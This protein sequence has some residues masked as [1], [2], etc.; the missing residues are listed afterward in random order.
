MSLVDLESFYGRKPV[1]ELLKKRV[2]DLKDGY[3]QNL[4]FLGNRFVGKS[5]ILYKFVTDLDDGDV[6]PVFVDVENNDLSSFCQRYI[7]SLL[8]Y[9]ARSKGL[10]SHEDIS[11]LMET[12]QSSLPQ[13]VKAMK[14]IQSLL[15]ADKGPEAYREVLVL[16]QLFALESNKFCLLILDEFD[17]LESFAIPDVFQEL[18]KRI[19]TQ[20]R[21]LYVVTSSF[22]TAASKIL[23]EK[24][25]LLF[26]NFEVV[27][28]APFD[29]KTS[30]G[31]VQTRVRPRKI[32]PAL[33]NFLVDFTGGH[34]L[35][36]RLI[37][38]ELFSL[39]AIHHQE[40]IF[41]PLLNQACENVLFHPWGVLSR[42]FEHLLNTVSSPREAYL[43]DNLLARLSEGRQKIKDL[44]K[45]VGI[46]ERLLAPTL[47][48]LMETGIVVK[49]G[50]FYYLPDKLLRYWLKYVFWKRRYAVD[51]DGPQQKKDFQA[52]LSAAVNNFLVSAEQDLATRVIE[53]FHC[54]GDEA[55]QINNRRYKLPLFRQIL[56]PKSPGAEGGEYDLITATADDGEWFIVLGHRKISEN[57]ISLI[58]QEFKRTET[59]P[60]RC[61]LIS[62]NDLDEGT[63]VRALQERMWIWNERELTTLLNIYNKPFILDEEGSRR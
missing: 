1:L 16:P 17:R 23:S 52:E 40:E 19:M 34:P 41:I 30:D 49:N 50:S 22:V 20:K 59:R 8:Y 18:G 61:I 38:D 7:T 36:L 10:P 60:Q 28:L 54:F 29:F 32:G 39:S 45:I 58:V 5:T 46:K 4:A 62:L 63:R 3:R 26:G 11:L 44:A 24:L 53:L 48:H 31:F 13:T 51:Y 12:T 14:K 56:P 55:L 6:I 35:Y 15:A 2:L 57:D 37:G 9:F 25:S 43:R 21:C 47:N 42:H 27:P 33:L